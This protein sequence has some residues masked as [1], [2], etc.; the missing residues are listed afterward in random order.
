MRSVAPMTPHI[1]EPCTAE[2][3]AAEAA[4]P[5]AGPAGPAADRAAAAIAGPRAVNPHLRR[6]IL[7]V[8]EI[9]R[10]AAWMPLVIALIPLTLAFHLT[11]PAIA[12]AERDGAGRGT[13][14]RARDGGWPPA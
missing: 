7:I 13:A 11:V 1:A 6:T 4:N 14:A 10:A 5:A 9:V 12:Q 8:G 3:T 2:P